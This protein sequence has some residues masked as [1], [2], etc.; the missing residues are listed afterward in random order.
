M[1]VRLILLRYALRSGLDDGPIQTIQKA[2]V[3]VSQIVGDLHVADGGPCYP[4]PHKART[5]CPGGVGMAEQAAKGETHSKC[6]L[7]QMPR[8]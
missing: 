8:S 2:G 1:L 7:F 3:N 4:D 6:A 5:D